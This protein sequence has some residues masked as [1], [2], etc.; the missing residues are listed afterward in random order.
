MLSG[1]R[2]FDKAHA[3]MHL[4]AQ[5]GD[6]NTDISGPCFCNR[7]EK[8]GAF[9][10]GFAL[11]RV[12]FTVRAIHCCCGHVADGARGIGAAAHE[13]EHTAH[14][15]MRDDGAHAIDRAAKRAALFAL[16]RISEC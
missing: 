7:G 5:R 11:F 13:H 10:R 16:G 14:I 4:N 8:G 1:A 6:F 2:A 3:A 15:R 9:F 12:C